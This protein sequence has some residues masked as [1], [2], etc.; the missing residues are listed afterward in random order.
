M[1]PPVPRV[2]SNLNVPSPNHSRDVNEAGP[3]D[4]TKRQDPSDWGVEQTEATQ[5]YPSVKVVQAC[6]SSQLDSLIIRKY[7]LS[8]TLA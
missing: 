7:H 5:E 2:F 8:S 6:P 1:D 3:S 4:G